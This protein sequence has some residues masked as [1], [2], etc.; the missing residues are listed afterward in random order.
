MSFE[1]D[2]LVSG[3]TGYGMFWY[4]PSLH[5]WRF[6]HSAM[7]FDQVTMILAVNTR[8]TMVGTT[9]SHIR[10]GEQRV[11]IR[12]V[13][14]ISQSRQFVYWKQIFCHNLFFSYVACIHLGNQK[15][16]IFAID[17][18]SFNHLE[19]ISLSFAFIWFM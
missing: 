19:L 15:T 2:Y 14:S 12:P 9:T 16:G 4:K 5:E 6:L 18:A 10:S 13:W 11:R 3:V 17:Q 1:T 8:H 7:C